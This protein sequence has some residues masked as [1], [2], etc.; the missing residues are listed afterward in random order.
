MVLAGIGLDSAV[1][2]RV[3]EL[4]NWRICCG[5]NSTVNK[6]LEKN[7]TNYDYRCCTIEGVALLQ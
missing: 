5:C 3:L 1:V 7:Q 6:L 4:E 2:E